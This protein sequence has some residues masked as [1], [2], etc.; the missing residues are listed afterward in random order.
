M[1]TLWMVVSFWA[2]VAACAHVPH[3]VVSQL[4]ASPAYAVDRTL[5]AVVRNHLLRS[6]D[7][8][9]SWVLL[10]RGLQTTP[11]ALLIN[12]QFLRTQT[13]FALMHSGALMQS[14]DAGTHW[15]PAVRPRAGVQL[16]DLQLDVADGGA[17][18]LVAIDA[19]GEM[20]SRSTSGARLDQ[21]GALRI[22]PPRAGAELRCDGRWRSGCDERRERISMRRF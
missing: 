6:R 15:H 22:T 10:H 1:R 7:G 14:R 16:A 20:W 17:A 11:R 21:V 5:F 4:L 3:D 19:V 8:A 2:A 12:P 18:Q 9:T 13:L